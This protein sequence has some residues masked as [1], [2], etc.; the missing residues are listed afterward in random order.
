M[1]E[2]HVERLKPFFGTRTE[3]V[4]LAKRDNGWFDVERI[5]A[6]RGDPATRTT[7]EFH[8]LFISG[9]VVWLP[10]S[11]DIFQMIQ[12]EDYCDKSPGLYFLK[13]SYSDSAKRQAVVNKQPITSL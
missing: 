10:F 8:V 2:Y 12:F 3:A 1:R 4:E 13:Y 6:Y 5:L 7:M 9:D 11:Q